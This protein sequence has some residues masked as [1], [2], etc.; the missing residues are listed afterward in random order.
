M[1][2]MGANVVANGSGAFNLTGLTPVG[3][4]SFAGHNINPI[5]GNIFMGNGAHTILDV[6]S[7]FTG[8]TN[9][10]SGGAHLADTGIG[11]FVGIERNRGQMFVPHPISPVLRYRAA[12]PGTTRPSPA[13]A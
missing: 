8:P 9:F 5:S 7:G 4:Q 11:D 3:S 13:S 10:G 1:E 12:R 2:Q 6:Y